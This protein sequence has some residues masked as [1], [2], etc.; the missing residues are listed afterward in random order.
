MNGNN[1][2]C[3]SM[4]WFVTESRT[5]MCLYTSERINS[6]NI[7]ETLENHNQ[8]QAKVVGKWRFFFCPFP[9]YHGALTPLPFVSPVP[10]G[11]DLVWNKH[12]RTTRGRVSFCFWMWLYSSFWHL[13]GRCREVTYSRRYFNTVRFRAM[14]VG[15]SD[16]L[17][18]AHMRGVVSFLLTTPETAAQ[19]LCCCCTPSTAPQLP[20]QQLCRQLLGQ[21]QELTWSISLKGWGLPGQ[22]QA[23]LKSVTRYQQRVSCWDGLLQSWIKAVN[24]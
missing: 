1:W 6:F 24:I 23:T 3:D 15:V 16:C 7:Y 19:C 11:E 22:A 20:K 12:V 9:L 17:R 21:Q 2:Q 5:L 8:L 4:E 18:Y 13:Q 14:D 10:T